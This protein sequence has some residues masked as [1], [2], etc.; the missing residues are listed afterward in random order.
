MT[1][2]ITEG[3]KHDSGMLADSNLLAVMEQHAIAP[4]GRRM[5]VYGDPAYPLRVHLQAPFRHVHLTPEMQAFN[6]GMNEA[7]VAV[8]W[9]FG[10]IA[11]YFKFLDFKKNLKIELSC[12]QHDLTLLLLL[13]EYHGLLLLKESHHFS[14]GW[15]VELKTSMSGNVSSSNSVVQARRM[16]DQLRVEVGMERFKVLYPAKTWAQ[17]ISL[18]AAE[19]AQYCQDHRC[20]DPLLTGIAASSNP[21]K[22]KKTC[23]LPGDLWMPVTKEVCPTSNWDRGF[24]TPDRTE[25]AWMVPLLSPA[26]TSPSW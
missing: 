19:L 16:V 15:S 5:C 17:E 23:R 9:L 22:D 26:H 6:K 25:K 11:N 1:V 3:K 4:D 10:D 24:R 7:R 18:A 2:T 21:F 13:L 12:S 14:I 8:E 20:S